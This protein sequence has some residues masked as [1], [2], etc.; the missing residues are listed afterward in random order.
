M[1]IIKRTI[2]F[3]AI[4]GF[5][6][7]ISF[8][9]TASKLSAELI[10]SSKELLVFEDTIGL[11]KDYL[12][13]TYEIIEN[14]S[15]NEDIKI[16]K[17]LFSLDKGQY[18]LFFAKTRNKI[19]SEGFKIST[20]RE[21]SISIFADTF[22]PSK[23]PKTDGLYLFSFPQIS[24]LDLTMTFFRYDLPLERTSIKTATLNRNPSSKI[25]H[26]NLIESKNGFAI[27]K[28]IENSVGI[29]L[30]SDVNKRKLKKYITKHARLYTLS[31]KPTW[32]L[33]QHEKHQPDYPG[34]RNFKSDI[35][36]VF[37]IYKDHDKYKNLHS[38]L[39]KHG[40]INSVTALCSTYSYYYPSLPFDYEIENAQDTQDVQ[41]DPVKPHNDTDV[42]KHDD[43][44]V[45]FGEL[46][47][48]LP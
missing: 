39:K 16:H 6:I 36:A 24:N 28:F 11:P 42:S 45:S 20:K 17:V 7:F 44:D 22:I 19:S 14:D 47:Y 37:R 32:Y 40:L 1:C 15:V 34:K 2:V 31:N 13:N 18:K 3:I 43:T 27:V 26:E 5:S 21:I 23:I 38:N 48:N 4:A 8:C 10:P 33:T 46:L 25:I 30:L 29:W 41:D 9:I 12:D 35:D